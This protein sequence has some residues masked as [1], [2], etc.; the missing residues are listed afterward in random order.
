MKGIKN[1]IGWF[2]GLLA[3]IS[4]L[5]FFLIKEDQNDYLKLLVFSKTEGFRHSSIEEGQK[6]LQNLADQN[7]FEVLFSEEAEVFNE[8]IL[9][10]VNVIVFLNTTG[11]ILDVAQQ[12]ELQRFIQAGGGFVG[13]HSA[14]DT[15]YKWPYYN[16][17]VGAYFESHPEPAEATINVLN[18]DHLSTHH[19]SQ[20]WVHTDEWYN[21]RAIH[22]DINVLMEVNEA[23]YQGGKNGP[24]HPIS[25]YRDFDGG[26]MWYTGLGHTEESYIEPLFIEHVWGG[27]QYA[28]GPM[29]RIDYRKSN[30]V[31]EENRFDIEVL[32]ENLNEPME[33]EVLP[34]GNV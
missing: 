12:L 31:P 6:M 18:R 19:L 24:N 13:I 34:N 21:Y 27:I 26:R 14:T 33:L 2:F 30:T 28:A 23:T 11:D 10:D 15:E 32:D 1:K 5:W 22:P 25:W 20:N 17:L 9:A 3:T 16:Q 7:G 8:K 4:G 29:Q